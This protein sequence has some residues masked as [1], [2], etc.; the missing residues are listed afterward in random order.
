MRTLNDLSAALAVGKTTSRQLVEDCLARIADPAGEGSRAFIKVD[1]EGARAAADAM[2]LMRRA[3]RALGPFAGIPFSVKDLAGIVGQ[4]T[5]AGS[6]VLADAAPEAANAPVVQRIA[7][8]GFVIMGR[9]NMTEFAF[10]GLG[11]NPHYGTPKSPWDRATGRIPGGS[12]SGAGVSI[13]DA[14]AYGALGTD[15]GG[16]CRIPAAMNGIVGTKP[17]ARRVPIT[18]VVP[19]STSLDSIGPLANS[20]ACCAAIDAVFAGEPIPDL[21]AAPLAGLR[22]GAPD[23]AVLEG[24][25]AEVANAFEAALSKLSAAGARIVRIRL[26][27]FDE[28]PRANARGTFAAAEAW[29]CHRELIAAKAGGYDPQVLKRIMPGQDMAAGDY[30]ALLSARAEICARANAA[31]QDFDAIVMPTC[32][33]LPPPIAKLEADSDEYTRVNMLQ[34]RNCAFGNFLDRCAISLPCTKRGEAPVGLMLMGETMGD[35]KLFRVA[36]AVEAALK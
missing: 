4:V 21:V 22:L 18:G 10:S 1:A 9:T 2:D 19:L 23:N 24:M 28:I 36:A 16:S 12:S 30:V 3:G 34:L 32:P 26:A 6:T 25:D 11:I 33:L 31:T 14:M 13:A 29:A 15:T 35:A 8:A 7:E 20:V 17:T 27:A 5:T